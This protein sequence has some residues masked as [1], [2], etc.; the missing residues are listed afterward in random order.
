MYV[1]KRV[2]FD[3]VRD[4]DLITYLDS[5]TSHKSN[6][7]IRDL[8]RSHMQDETESQLDR[9]ERTLKEV[10]KKIS[11]GLVVQKEVSVAKDT[12]ISNDTLINLD[13]LGV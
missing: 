6:Q 4:R 1:E 11:S 3:P 2:S 9:I 8:L 5:M 13:N 12:T 10:N 7:L